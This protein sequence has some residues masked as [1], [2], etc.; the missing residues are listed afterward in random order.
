MHVIYSGLVRGGRVEQSLGSLPE[1][2]ARVSRGP[3]GHKDS[4]SR[5][6]KYR[7]ARHVQGL[8]PVSVPQNFPVCSQEE[9]LKIIGR[10]L[11]IK[12]LVVRFDIEAAKSY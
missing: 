5:T 1:R 9:R 10:A 3:H 8:G 11:I 4:I 7:K 6:Q 12:A 2:A